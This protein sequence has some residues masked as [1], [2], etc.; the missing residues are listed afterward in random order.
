[1]VGATEGDLN[2]FDWPISDEI[3][4][5]T[6][7]MIAAGK[8][9]TVGA[10]IY[11]S[12]ARHEALNNTLLTHNNIYM[13]Y[14]F[15]EAEFE[16]IPPPDILLETNQTGF[17][18]VV[19][20]PGGVVRRGLLFLN[21]DLGRFGTGFGLQL[22]ARYLFND[23]VCLQSD[24][25]EANNLM[26]GP[27]ASEEQ[28]TENDT[29]SAPIVLLPFEQNDGGYVG[30]D[31]SGYQIMMD[32]VGG[33][34]RIPFLTQSLSDVYDGKVDPEFFEERVV[35]VGVTAESVKDFFFT[36]FSSDVTFDQS[37]YGIE[38]HAHLVDQLLRHGLDGR[39]PI[40]FLSDRQETLLVWLW[41]MLGAALGYFTR[42]AF[43]F[44][45]L[46]IAGIA[47]IWSAASA[48]FLTGLWIPIF[49]SALSW[50]IAAFVIM[51]YVTQQE[52]RQRG[53]LMGI[54][55]RH[56]S[57]DVA[58]NLWKQR[59]EFMDGGRPKPQRITATLLF[60][61]LKGFTSVSENMD[62]SQLMEW[63]I[64]YMEAMSDVVIAHGGVIDKF[65]GDA[66]M[67][68]FGVPNKRETEEE[69]AADARSAVDC[70]L[71][72][73]DVLDGLNEQ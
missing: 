17:A 49:P 9:R 54:F 48:L 11:R 21:N 68:V 44:A 51:S 66:I 46:A 52:S 31:A 34:R 61:D 47:V 30:A 73:A 5:E 58:E 29:A 57:S 40:S 71:A 39:P 67:A 69:I 60:T 64:R 26:F 10:D 35:I 16:G 19:L 14:K 53:E 45:V 41:S 3:L 23:S 12:G 13:V 15:R 20:D 1:M 27:C 38:V 6:L 8:P 59:D 18:D 25:T 4:A 2:R 36:P 33:S 63:L 50:F 56:V 42:S 37:I 70:A 43:R 65:I 72:M 22:A 24:G 32:Y 7:E 62:P 55:S 28:T